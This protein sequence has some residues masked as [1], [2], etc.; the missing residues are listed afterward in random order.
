MGI[1]G[2]WEGRLAGRD[3]ESC[4]RILGPEAVNLGPYAFLRGD[5]SREAERQRCGPCGPLGDREHGA[6]SGRDWRAREA[7]HGLEAG[8]TRLRDAPLAAVLEGDSRRLGGDAPDVEAADRVAG[9]APV[10]PVQLDR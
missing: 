10:A 3:V 1:A 8:Q 4:A 5:V 7:E 2:P 6:A 9:V